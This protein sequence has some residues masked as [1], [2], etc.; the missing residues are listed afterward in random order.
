M[1]ENKIAKIINPNV[2]MTILAFDPVLP[3]ELPPLPPSIGGGGV[4]GDLPVFSRGTLGK[5]SLGYPPVLR[6]I[7]HMSVAVKKKNTFSLDSYDKVLLQILSKPCEY[8]I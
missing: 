1:N 4:I 8:L 2:G 6:F 5:R 3:P 7:H